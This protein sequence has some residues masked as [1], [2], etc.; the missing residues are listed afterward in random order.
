[1]N[2]YTDTGGRASGR[3]L[4]ALLTAYEAAKRGETVYFVTSTSMQAKDTLSTFYHTFRTNEKFHQ[5]QAVRVGRGLVLFRPFR[6]NVMGYRGRVIFDHH[7]DES[8]TPNWDNT[9]QY[10]QW[11]AVGAGY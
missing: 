8:M 11:A 10:Q 6:C 2:T 7:T 5:D 9:G 1:M 4:R 3:T